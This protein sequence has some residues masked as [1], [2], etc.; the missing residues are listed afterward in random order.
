MMI[1]ILPLC[2]GVPVLKN[3]VSHMILAGFLVSFVAAQPAQST[4]FGQGAYHRYEASG[5]H[6]VDSGK[7]QTAGAEG[8]IDQVAKH[9][10]SFLSNPELSDAQREKEFRKLLTNSFDI[11]TIARFS[12]G[13]HW[14]EMSDSQRNEY[15]GLFKDMIVKVYSKRFSEYDG[16]QLQ[17]TGA[18]TNEDGDVLVSSHLVAEGNP[19]VKVDWR[20]RQKGSQF[21]IVDVI[22]E[23]V[24][25]A[26]TQRSDFS[27]VIQRGGGD[28][29]VLL[30]HLRQ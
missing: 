21:K 5:F 15:L 18:R 13:R 30:V 17:V 25:M 7:S 20:V 1:N 27:S 24:S 10:I 23:G 3:S 9:G 12:L 8:F 16:Q 19:Q 2:F 14:R 26:L 6:L 29:G 28:V 11:N 22:V 4:E